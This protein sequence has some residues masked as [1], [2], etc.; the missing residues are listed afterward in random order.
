M[1]FTPFLHFQ[2]QCAEAMGFYAQ[3]FGTGPALISRYSDMPPATD[4]PTPSDRVMFSQIALGDHF[5]QASDFPEGVEGDP[6]KAVSVAWGSK[7]LEQAHAV[8]DALANGGAVIMPF[9]AT[10]WSMGFGMVKDRFG[11]HWMISGPL[12]A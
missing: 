6:Q 7:D 12:T 4:G 3:V 2:G 1:T 11:T 9:A 10:F 5:L 8:F